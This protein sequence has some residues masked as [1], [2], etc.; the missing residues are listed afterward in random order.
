MTMT[1]LRPAST[2]E[3]ATGAVL[4][5]ALC[6]TAL[7]ASE[8]MPV[9]LLTPIAAD[10]GVTEGRAG[11]AISISG[12]FAV[13]TSLSVAS[14]TRGI[15][16]KTVL[17][18]F[19][20]MLILSGLIVTFA[21][22]YLTLM[23][24]RSMLG[25]AVGGFWGMSTAIIM[26]LVPAG[27]VPWGLATL[28]AGVAIAATVSAPLGAFLGEIIGWRG[29]FFLVVPLGLA[30]LVW[31]RVSMPSLPPLGR[32][33]RVNVFALLLRPQVALGMSAILL[34]FVGQFTLFTYLRP[35]LEGVAGYSV[36]SL[37]L[38]LL[39][40]GLAGVVGSWVVSKLLTRHLHVINIAI[41]LLMASV[42][43]LLI[44]VTPRQIPIA[45]LLMVWGF[46]ATAAPVGWGTWV[47]RVVPDDAE[48]GG[49]LQVAVIQFAIALGAAGGGFMFDRVGWS[50]TFGCAA[51]LLVGSAVFAVAATL[52]W[53]RRLELRQ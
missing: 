15:D 50:G 9:S 48:E 19:S 2:A 30:A 1:S 5:M 12:L 28:N 18:A 29:A 35:Y 27:D 46:V 13:I 51:A 24:G 8:F 53:K 40:L 39:G 34:L 7:I 37:S 31:Q 52:H 17:S 44:A 49:G 41:P 3:P 33:A 45:V 36:N 32:A 38:V 26:R 25:I 4:S 11:Q 6:V 42:A 23:V 20:A 14:V 16:R 47:S 10:L 22:D 21:P 43:V